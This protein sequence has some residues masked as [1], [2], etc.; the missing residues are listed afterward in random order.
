[1]KAAFALSDQ[2]LEQAKAGDANAFE[3][4]YNAYKHEVYTLCLRKTGDIQ[5]AEDLTQ[6]VFVRVY[7]KVNG[8][9]GD[10][11]FTT[12]LYRVTLNT[13]MMHFRKHRVEL[14][15]ISDLHDCVT[16]NIADDQD[17]LPCYP[18]H[19]VDRIALARAISDLG[20]SARQAVVLHDIKGLSYREIATLAGVPV[21]TSKAEVWR[22][23][24]KMRAILRP[25]G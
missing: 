5:D 3:A 8:F 23:H 1:M 14:R 19:P 24:R 12:W 25:A 6:E 11:A 7:R 2:V 21:S 15:P 20:Q 22:A 18:C 16:R 10:A 9:R 13:V 4:L 17:A